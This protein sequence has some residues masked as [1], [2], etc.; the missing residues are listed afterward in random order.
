[1]RLT[2]TEVRG[3]RRINASTLGVTGRAFTLP[4]GRLVHP[5]TLRSLREKHLVYDHVD[6]YVEL[7]RKGEVE[8]E[9]RR[10]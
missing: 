7:T 8:L 1:M 3:L 5:R 10:A 6:G 4:R 9:R 2:K